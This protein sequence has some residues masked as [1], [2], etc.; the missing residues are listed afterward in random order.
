MKFTEHMNDSPIERGLTNMK[1][2]LPLILFT[3][4]AVPSALIVAYSIFNGKI[5]GKH[6]ESLDPIQT[7]TVTPLS[8]E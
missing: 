2:G 8:N 4:W 6:V 1:T 5:P 3:A 7:I